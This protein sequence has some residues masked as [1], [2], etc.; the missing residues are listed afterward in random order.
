MNSSS[1]ESNNILHLFHFSF[2]AAIAEMLVQ[3]TVNDLYLL[4]ALPRDKWADGCVK[5]LK[6][7]GGVA[8]NICCKEDVSLE[9]QAI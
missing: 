9:Q 1:D 2:S 3:N 7:R 8:V 5:G 6:A 4:P